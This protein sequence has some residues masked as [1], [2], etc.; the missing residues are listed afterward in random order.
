MENGTLPL[1]S[2]AP[3]VVASDVARNG[4]CWG[5]VSSQVHHGLWYNLFLAAPVVVFVL[6][7]A[8]RARQSVSKLLHSR[9]NIMATYYAFLWVVAFLNLIWFVLKVR[10]A[11]DGRIMSWNIMSLVVSFGMVLLEV[12]VVVFL[13]QGYL[14]SGWD[15]LTRTLVCSGLVAT[16]DTFIKAVYIFG[17]GVPLFLAEADAGYWEKWT[18]WLVRSML[19]AGIYLFILILPHTSLRDRLPGRRFTIG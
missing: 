11:K 10:Q 18:F 13:S 12:S 16:A 3:E 14:V 9:S 6:F 4:A 7:L 2:L 1:P 17:L 8:I 5:L 19:F 15:A